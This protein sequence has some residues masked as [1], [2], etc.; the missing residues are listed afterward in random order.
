MRS[1]QV[2]AGVP[3][4]PCASMASLRVGLL[5]T[6]IVIELAV[7]AYLTYRIVSLYTSSMRR[8]RSGKDAPPYLRKAFEGYEDALA[9]QGGDDYGGKKKTG[10]VG[11][12]AYFHM[13]GCG[14][15]QRFEPTWAAFREEHTEH[16]RQMGISLADFDA[17][18]PETERY[19]VR[20]FPTVL[21]IKD[22]KKRDTFAESPRTVEALMAF[23]KK[24]T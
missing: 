1:G 9:T 8:R 16:L 5:V 12:I 24:N 21:F 20:A 22:G 11:Q 2:R 17:R 3:P 19:G 18:A 6:L 14:Y 13:Q 15:C 10:A 4:S 7:I 23:A